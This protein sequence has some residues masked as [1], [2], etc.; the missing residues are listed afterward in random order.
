MHCN[1]EHTH[2]TEL[3][4]GTMETRLGLGGTRYD[5]K[6]L[7][8]GLTSE[9]GRLMGG[10]ALRILHLNACTTNL[11]LVLFGCMVTVLTL[12]HSYE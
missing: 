4:I 12:S 3:R 1:V 8:F 5:F 9:A 11:L 6:V 10:V 7:A 2:K